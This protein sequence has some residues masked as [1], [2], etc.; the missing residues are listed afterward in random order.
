M[1]E[2]RLFKIIYHLLER[3][4][5]TAPELA[6]K[7]EV[8][9]RTIYRDV[10]ALSEAG[11]PI[12]TEPGRNGG[13]RLLENFVLNRAVLSE[14]EK[15]EVLASLQ[16]LGATGI[17]GTDILGK[18]SALF[19]AEGESWL[20]VDFSRWGY[21]QSD[22]EKFE[23][24]KT[25]VIHRKCVKF[26]YAGSD[27]TTMERMVWPLKLSYKSKAWYLKA[28]CTVRKD[29]RLF[30]LSRILSWK[31]L[32]E[33]F[34]S[35][36]CPGKTELR[37]K[38]YSSEESP[39]GKYHIEE[40]PLKEYPAIVLRFPNEVSYRVYDEFD[41]AD[42]ERTEDGGLS[43]HFRVP[44]DDWLVGFLLSFGEKVEIVEPVRLKQ[45]LAR[46]AEAIYRKNKP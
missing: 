21:H 18:I 4:Q 2:S 35:C 32:E 39:P 7:F 42:V 6:K 3:G 29:F 8:S 5:A 11:I 22:N 31:V 14:E 38:G 36:T 23:A 17:K 34:A 20:E 1:Q 26:A 28:Y 9:V 10:D 46:Q 45:M 12:Y 33:S 43:V 30:K 19:D 15:Q 24:L 37:F 41:P 25:A 27:G 40:Y 16:S 44:V 13:I